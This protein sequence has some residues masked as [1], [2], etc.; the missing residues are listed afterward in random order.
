MKVSVVGAGAIGSLFGGLLKHYAPEIDVLLIGRGPHGSAVRD[1]GRLILQGF[2][3]EFPT[4][5]RSSSDLA[6]VAGSDYVLFTVKSHAT[7]ETIA[8][9]APNLGQAVLISIQ[10]GIN[11]RIL[12]QHMPPEQLVIGMTAT[13]VAIVA[14]AVVSLQLTGMTLLGPPTPGRLTPAAKDAAE[15]LSRTGLRVHAYGN[16]LGAQYNK[17]AVNALGYAAVLSR[18]NIITEGVL[19]RSWR[20]AV[21]LPILKECMSVFDRAGIR[22]APIPG[23]PDISS[24]RFLLFLFGVPI[25]SPIGGFIC[26]FFFNRKPIIFSLQQ[27]LERRKPTEIEFING[28]VVRL[29][30][31]V[32][33]AAPRNAKV[34]ELVHQLEQRGDASFFSR[35]EVVR[36][37]QEM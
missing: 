8:A 19:N 30:Q 36:V 29:A 28:E 20:K 13:N 26:R 1:T 25:V 17:L 15:L 5:I 34:V 7:E 31:A 23:M 16:T 32:G 4:A 3:G 12:A 27:D 33:L 18:S 21:A 10:N 9:I 14:P 11:G 22:L 24:F 35:D 37:F 6:D 2:W